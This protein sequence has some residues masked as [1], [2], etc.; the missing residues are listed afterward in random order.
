MPHTPGASTARARAVAVPAVLALAASAV[1]AT[2]LTAPASAA[3][4]QQYR[5]SRSSVALEVKKGR[6]DPWKPVVALPSGELRF[7]QTPDRGRVLTMADDP[8]HADYVAVTTVIEPKTIVSQRARVNLYRQH[9]RRGKV[10]SIMAVTGRDGT[11]YQ[12]GVVRTKAGALMWAVWV[13]TPEGKTVDI[14]TGH[15]AHLREWHT[16]E[17]NTRWGSKRSRASLTVDKRIEARTPRRDLTAVAGERAILGLGRVSKRTET[18]VLVVASATV[19]GAAPLAVAGIGSTPPPPVAT[20]VNRAQDV[21]PGTELLRADYET[22]DLSQWGAFQR[23]AADRIQVV[24]SPV[25]QGKYA[26]RF[27]VRNG[28]NPIGYGDRAEV[29]R[30]TGESEGEQRWYAWSTMLASDFPRTNAWQVISQWHAN[31]DGSPPLA[32]FAEG[33]SIVLQA[34]RFSGPGAEIDIKD[35]WTGPMRRGQWQDIQLHVKWSGSDSVGFVELWIDGVQQRFDDGTTKRF[36]RTLTPGVGAYF[37]QGLY[38][39]SG[40]A[41]TG[42]VYHDGFRMSTG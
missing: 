29:Q 33:D 1:V 15:Y 25:R 19:T 10:R 14:R 41:G 34:H 40:I 17:L 4:D 24:A 18:G 3:R 12:A 36:I 26:A 23:V 22:G 9:L 8:T 38:R 27:E 20:P 21:L 13:K 11:S 37:K 31:A 35:I 39:Q 32:F 30:G 16:M 7:T 6:I 2:V 42:V 5:L 28:D